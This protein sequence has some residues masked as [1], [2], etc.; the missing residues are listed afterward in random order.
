MSNLL[1]SLF[2]AASPLILAAVTYLSVRLASLIKA[3]TSNAYL[4]GVLLRLNDAV[5][6]AVK[7]VNQTMVEALK[8]S[9]GGKLSETSKQNAKLAA[10]QTIKAHLGPKGIAELA[11]VFGV[12]GV[13]LDNLLGTR[14]EAAVGASKPVPGGASTAPFFP[15]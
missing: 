2:Q 5:V 9:D 10:L 7:E 12:A 11:E 13:A 14:I 15:R 3:K 6:V 4:Q 8:A 1:W